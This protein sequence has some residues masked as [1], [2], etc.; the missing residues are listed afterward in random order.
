MDK[1]RNPKRA[2][3]LKIVLFVLALGAFVMVRA[4]GLLEASDDRED[5]LTLILNVEGILASSFANNNGVQCTLYTATENGEVRYLFSNHRDS[6]VMGPARGEDIA[7]AMASR[8][9]V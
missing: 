4:Q 3:M 2:R 7:S 9:V 1:P 8:Y 6:I 5:L